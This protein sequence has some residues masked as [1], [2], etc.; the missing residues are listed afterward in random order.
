MDKRPSRK[1]AE[2]RMKLAPQWMADSIDITLSCMAWPSG[3][4][5]VVNEPAQRSGKF[6]RRAS[7]PITIEPMAGSGVPKVG[8]PDRSDMLERKLP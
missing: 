7:W 3:S 2:C 6:K 4:L 5:E 1:P 8:E